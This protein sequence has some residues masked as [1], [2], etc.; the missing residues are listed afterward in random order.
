[1]TALGEIMGFLAALRSSAAD[2]FF[3]QPLRTAPELAAF[4][5]Q[6]AAYIAQTSLFG[7]LKTRMGTSFPQYFEDDGFARAIKIASVRVFASAAADLSVHAVALV[8]REGGLDDEAAAA[9]AR[10]CFAAALEAVVEP[11]DARLI[12]ADAARAFAARVALTAWDAAA[13]GQA[14]FAGSARD[15]IRFAPVTEEFKALDGEIVRNS[16]RFRWVNVRDQLRRRMRAAD[17]C[18]DWRAGAA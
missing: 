5:G 3:P 16:M 4:V 10:F 11:E 7:Y 12:P 18:A 14:A 2:R 13:A 8:R 9:L 15:L 6:R 1:M 17:I